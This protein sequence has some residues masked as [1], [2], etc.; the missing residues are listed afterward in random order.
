MFYGLALHSREAVAVSA[1]VA[2]RS[3]ADCSSMEGHTSL[4]TALV[5]TKKVQI[6]PASDIKIRIV[7]NKV[8][9]AVQNVHY[10]AGTKPP[11]CN[12]D[13][14]DGNRRLALL[15]KYDLRKSY[16]GNK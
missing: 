5:S 4:S 7:A 13:H 11:I 3:C 2:T 6:S 16:N 8:I 9:I 12:V 14:K 1:A 10:L 15:L